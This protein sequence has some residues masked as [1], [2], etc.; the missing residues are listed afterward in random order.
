MTNHRV[1]LGKSN[2]INSRKKFISAILWLFLFSGCKTIE[3]QKKIQTYYFHTA[4]DYFNNITAIEKEFG[5]ENTT[6]IYRNNNKDEFV[7]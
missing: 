4:Q 3:P 6:I 7:R 2:G 1:V 5:K